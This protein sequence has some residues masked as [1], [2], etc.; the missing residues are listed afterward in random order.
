VLL[1]LASMEHQPAVESLMDRM[2]RG[3]AK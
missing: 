2:R 1:H 3:D